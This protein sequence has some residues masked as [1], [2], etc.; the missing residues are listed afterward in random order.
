MILA[1]CDCVKGAGG[2]AEVGGAIGLMATE[3]ADSAAGAMVDG[4]A[5]LVGGACR[6]GAG[7][8]RRTIGSAMIG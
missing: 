1:V 2:A 7:S 5:G 6:C 8:G 4:A 3:W